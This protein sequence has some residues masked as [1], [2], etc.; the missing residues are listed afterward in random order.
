MRKSAKFTAA[1]NKEDK[2]NCVD[3]V[4]QMVSFCEKEGGKIPKFKI[5]AQL[6]IVDKIVQDLKDYTRSLIYE[7]AT[8]AR[9]IEDYIKKKEISDEIKKERQAAKENSEEYEMSDEDI[10]NYQNTIQD[11]KDK[12]LAYVYK[13]V[14]EMDGE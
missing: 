12:D 2:N 14:S 7:D 10:V 11:L 3:S 1:Q 5:E 8:L 6:D 4:G 13:D 9:Q